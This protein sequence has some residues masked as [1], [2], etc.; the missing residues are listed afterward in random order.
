[1]GTLRLVVEGAVVVVGIRS[2]VLGVWKM[3]VVGRAQFCVYHA[4]APEVQMYLRRSV[5][6]VFT[7]K[8]DCMMAR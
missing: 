2:V 8:N 4:I 1:M 3:V 5:P 7:L 6:L